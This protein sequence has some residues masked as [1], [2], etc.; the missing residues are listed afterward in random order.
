[1]NIGDTKYFTG[2]ANSDAYAFGY[3][4]PAR[5]AQ[6]SGGGSQGY[7]RSMYANTLQAAPSSNAGKYAGSNMS[8]DPR[9]TSSDLDIAQGSTDGALATNQKA[10]T[11][12]Q[13]DLNGRPRDSATAGIYSGG[14]N[15]YRRVLRR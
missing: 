12:M 4:D 7:R 10:P 8:S 5:N 11:V 14:T 6:G 15:K 1:M 3:V 9:L 2:K 13:I